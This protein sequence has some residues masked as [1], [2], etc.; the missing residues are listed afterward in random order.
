LVR[1]VEENLFQK[2]KPLVTVYSYEGKIN[3]NEANKSVIKAIYPELTDDDLTK[4]FEEKNRIGEWTSEQA[5]VDFITKTLGRNGFSE[6]YKDPKDY[7]F[8]V[9][10]YS[11]LVEGV[12]TIA[13][14]KLAI[15]KK[16]RAAVALTSAKG[17]AATK[18]VASQAE[19]EKDTLFFW[20]IN[21]GICLE[22][23]TDSESC[24]G[25]GEWKEKNG[26]LGCEVLVAGNDTHFITPPTAT[27]KKEPNALKI[28]Y[29]MET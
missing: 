28:L 17:A 2:L 14:N 29:W 27:T 6:R 21:P 19:C 9:Q 16:I 24:S 20:R 22:R 26:V 10:S 4:I 3:L 13:K 18:N 11:F 1:S 12:G 8:T 5:F 15:Q 25:L 7:P 23:P